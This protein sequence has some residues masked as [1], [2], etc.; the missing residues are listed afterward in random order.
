MPNLEENTGWGVGTAKLISILLGYYQAGETKFIYT[1]LTCLN[2][3]Y[4]QA[5]RMEQEIPSSVIQSEDTAPEQS[6]EVAPFAKYF[7]R[8]AI[9]LAK[10]FSHEVIEPEFE[11]QQPRRRAT[12]NQQ[13]LLAELEL[14]QV[15]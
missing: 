6:I 14:A 1:L 9:N 13:E 12:K 2:N 10:D 5:I 3:S 7:I 4:S 15:E 8:E 11:Q